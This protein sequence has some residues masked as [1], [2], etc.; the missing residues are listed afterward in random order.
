MRLNIESGNWSLSVKLYI[1]S[2]S[3]CFD[4]LWLKPTKRQENAA[5]SCF[6][7]WQLKC[8]EKQHI[9]KLM[10]FTPAS[11]QIFGCLRT[12]PVHPC[13]LSLYR[14]SFT[15]ETAKK[16]AGDFLQ[17][18]IPLGLGSYLKTHMT[19]KYWRSVTKVISV[20]LCHWKV[21]IKTVRSTIFHGQVKPSLLIHY[22]SSMIIIHH[23]WTMTLFCG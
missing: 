12:K 3:Q 20:S 13:F 15:A 5:V 2:F 10:S 7:I 16:R 8:P 14:L 21:I 6:H 19:H 4:F 17:R 1:K 11:R 23:I 9:Y 18:S 22:Y